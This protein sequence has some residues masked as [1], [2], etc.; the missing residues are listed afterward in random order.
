MATVFYTL[1]AV[2]Y[3]V[4]TVFYTVSMISSIASTALSAK[5]LLS[6]APSVGNIL[7][8]GILTPTRYS[9]LRSCTLLGAVH[10]DQPIHS[11]TSSFPSSSSAS[12]PFSCF[13][14][15]LKIFLKLFIYF[16]LHWVFIA[17][18]RLSVVAK[19]GVYSLV[20]VGRGYSLI[21]VCGLLTAVASL[22]VDPR[23]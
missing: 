18:C 22:V 11:I 8:T 5:I 2:S 23:L 21:A 13:L 9:D 16:W 15:I 6:E 3:T 17:A 12:I 1:P 7:F 4:S 19:S 20:A 14:L 10:T